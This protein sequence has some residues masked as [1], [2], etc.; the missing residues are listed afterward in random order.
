MS[1]FHR[2][3]QMLMKFI[4][5]PY[6]KRKK[7]TR[8]IPRTYYARCCIH[9]GIYEG[10]ILY[11][12]CEGRAMEGNPLA[13]FLE[14]ISRREFLLYEHI[15]SVE[16]EEKKE[17]YEEEWRAFPKVHFVVRHSN[18][19]V[20]A[21][22]ECK[23]L[24]NDM[25]FPPYFM[26]RK[27]QVYLN[28][29][30]GIPIKN[31]GYEV[32]DGE[33]KSANIIRNFLAADYLVSSGEYMTKVYRQSFRLQGIFN[34]TVL[35]TGM[36]H[37]DLLFRL[38]KEEV[39]EHLQRR[40]VTLDPEKELIL[41]APTFRGEYKQA[42]NQ[43]SNYKY[44]Y[45]MIAKAL[46]QRKYQLL[47][48]PHPAEY[49]MFSKEEIEQGYYIPDTV[50]V[51]E[52]LPIASLL[53]SDVSSLLFD[54]LL[55]ERPVIFY[56]PDVRQYKE[57]RGMR[58]LQKELPGP[59]TE[60]I[61]ELVWWLTHK[62]K[63]MREYLPLVCSARER[64]CC[65]E[66]GQAAGRVV[67]ALFLQEYEKE[68][69]V[70]L[71]E[72]EKKKLLFYAGGL[73]TNGI[74]VSL[75]G[76]LDLM[77]LEKYDITVY[78]Q[79]KQEEGSVFAASDFREGVRVMV[80]V[81]TYN[82]TQR[83]EFYHGVVSELGI[84]RAFCERNYPEEMYE[85]EYRRCFGE[86][87]FDEVI[88][89]SGYGS[90]MARVLLAAPEGKKRIWQHSDMKRDQKRT[91]DGKRPL[92]RDLKV[93][94]SLYGRFDSIV[95]CGEEMMMI[96]RKSLATKETYDK[97]CYVDN[98]VNSNRIKKGLA[99]E[100]IMVREGK[101]Y[102]LLAGQ[103]QGNTIMAEKMI[104]LPERPELS[105]IMVGR[106]SPEKNPMAA[107][108]AFEQFQKEVAQA[109]L[110][111]VGDG[112]LSEQVRRYVS[113]HGLED[114]VCLTGNLYNPF[115]LIRHCGCVLI[116]S[117][118][119]GQALIVR[120]MRVLHKAILISDHKGHEAVCEKDGQRIIHTDKDSIYEG[121]MAYYRGEV[122]IA[123]WE[124]E[125]YNAKVK[126]QMEQLLLEQNQPKWQEEGEEDESGEKQGCVTAAMVRGRSAQANR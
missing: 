120:E 114:S 73:R 42:E 75:M 87:V 25:T 68:Q 2:K 101:R 9:A 94:F 8:E 123:A 41:Y 124:C 38:S 32:P 104:L 83:E 118:W 43:S 82:A 21:L 89:Y 3:C 115:P 29:W 19:Y 5:D 107:L 126:Q 17:Q 61:D 14:I 113:R 110:Y 92:E 96:N 59:V 22:A 15:W 1:E 64:Y 95:S 60:T 18:A 70:S 69:A 20:K 40:G 105:F 37:T 108:Q 47:I 55:L 80:R 77:D 90:F 34:G 52:V 31:I 51:T 6:E 74:T 116:P 88:D 66:D 49:R 103:T 72:P 24:I 99:A 30:H 23:Y 117:K 63:L 27:G 106:L 45:E 79:S 125:Q 10:K 53:I 98:P 28:T 12:A 44:M 100:Q 112:P 102:L 39:Y 62:E 65:K 58:I 122:P 97:F 7:D 93:V 35:E 85:R 67:D 109:K 16:S 4:K 26:K 13:L 76:L 46:G 78:V 119:E 91:V 11:E 121:M 54:Y 57:D 71:R 81:P 111:M 33:R 84:S 86:A 56:I 36:P 50:D 48:K